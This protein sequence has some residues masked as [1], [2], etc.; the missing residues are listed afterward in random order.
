M[1][2]RSSKALSAA[3]DCQ[4]FAGREDGCTDRR[5]CSKTCCNVATASLGGPGRSPLC[6]INYQPVAGITAPE[7]RSVVS[8]SSNV[9]PFALPTARGG[10][11]PS[12]SPESVGA[13]HPIGTPAHHS[14][15]PRE[16]R[17]TH[18]D[19]RGSE[20]SACLAGRAKLYYPCLQLLL[21]SGDCNRPTG[22]WTYPPKVMRGLPA[23]PA[24]L[25]RSPALTF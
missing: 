3:K 1:Q 2:R 6:W 21:R 7:G 17:V 4:A 13:G 22:P 16:Q 20:K 24:I 14:F 15:R 5:F 11:N 12:R 25:A 18:H 9:P 19:P 23:G 8:A 10:F